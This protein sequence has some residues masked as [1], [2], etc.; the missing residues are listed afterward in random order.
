[1][2][3]SDG[4]AFVLFTSYRTLRDAAQRLEDFFEPKGWRLV[5]CRATACRGTG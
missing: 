2:S 3:E 4:R 1:M 5:R